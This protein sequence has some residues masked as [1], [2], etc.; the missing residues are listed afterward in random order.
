VAA[1]TSAEV[2]NALAFHLKG[3]TVA[4]IPSPDLLDAQVTEAMTT[5][6]AQF[7]ERLLLLGYTAAQV[8][9]WIGETLGHG[10]HLDQTLWRLLRNLA[11]L[12]ADD[13]WVEK[14]N[15]LKDFAPTSLVIDGVIVE[16]EGEEAGSGVGRLSFLDGVDLHGC[17]GTASPFTGGSRIY[18]GPGY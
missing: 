14:F 1:L 3:N 4:V 11:N 15:V 8:T 16:P 2:K 10:Y 13:L 9:S 6:G 5:A 17:R 18:N 12:D 7:Q